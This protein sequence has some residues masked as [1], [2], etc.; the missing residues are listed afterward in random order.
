MFASSYIGLL[1]FRWTANI[2]PRYLY[3]HTLLIISQ[4]QYSD[5]FFFFTTDP[6]PYVHKSVIK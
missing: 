2:K 4:V 6:I 5:A 1:K 3:E